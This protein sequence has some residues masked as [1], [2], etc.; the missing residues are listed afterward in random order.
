MIDLTTTI[1]RKEGYA[2]TEV[3]GNKVLMSVES[4][5]YYGLNGMGTEIWKRIENFM[6]VST[7]IEDLLNE[8]E[9]SREDA[10]AQVLT[11]LK[12]LDKNNLIE[13][14]E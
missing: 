8:Y 1:K 10:E 2:D 7:L 11:F 14:S 6:T 13:K 3:D 5:K 12:D 4:G 9:V